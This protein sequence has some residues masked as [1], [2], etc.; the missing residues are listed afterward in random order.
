VTD[1][2]ESPVRD[3]PQRDTTPLPDP[4]GADRPRARLGGGGGSVHLLWPLLA[5]AGVLLFDLLFSPGFFRVSMLDGRLFGSTIDILNRGAPVLLLSLGMTLVIATGGVDLS[6]GAVMAICGALAAGLVARPDFFVLSNLPPMS[7]L[8][9]IAVALLAGL[10]CGLWNGALVALLDIQPIIATLIL[11]VAGRGVAQL[12][13]DG[14]QITFHDPTLEYVGRGVLLWLPFPITIAVAGFILIALLTRATALGLFI[15]SVGN[16][17]V[18][19]RYCGVNTRLVKLLAY[20][21]SGLCAAAAGLIVTADNT[22]SDANSTGLY[23]ELDAILAVVIGGTALT[24]GR[25]FLLGSV[26]GAIL[27]QA[28]TTTIL[29]TRFVEGGIP[30]QVTLVVKAAVV[31]AVCL[32]QAPRFRE[33]VARLFTRAT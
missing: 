6:V 11:M 30:P 22:Q 1:Q 10:I 9:V 33:R 7:P 32:L 3:E 15:E 28:L 16:N 14:Q 20:A 23:L 2:I 13:S 18:A 29:T 4:G 31:I 27:I 12:L 8:L 5:L 24:G 17:P 26:I 25:F 19:A 21:V